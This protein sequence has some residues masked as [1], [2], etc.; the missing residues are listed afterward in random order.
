VTLKQTSDA[1]GFEPVREWMEPDAFETE[2]LEPR[3]FTVAG[4]KILV[5]VSGWL[6][7]SSSGIELDFWTWVVWTFDPDGLATQVEIYLDREQAEA[8]DAAGL[9]SA[10]E[11]RCPA[12]GVQAGLDRT[13]DEAGPA[14]GQVRAGEEQIAFRTAHRGVVVLVPAGTV[15]C[16]GTE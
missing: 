11:G 10:G 13:V 9:A 15:D 1:A 6:Q 7:G 5:R 14:V 2:V 4:D 8:L 3:D 16:P 12:T